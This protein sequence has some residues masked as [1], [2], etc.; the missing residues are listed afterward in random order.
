M[1]RRS[2]QFGEVRSRIC[3]IFLMVAMVAAV[4]ALAASLYRIT[5]TG[6]LPIMAVQLCFFVALIFF[7]LFRKRLPYRLCAGFVVAALLTLGLGG[8]WQVG[9]V[10]SAVVFLVV[11]PAVS[12]MFFGARVGIVILIA[13]AA[14]TGVIGAFTVITERLPP[15]D[16]SYYA[17]QP[18]SWMTM[19]VAWSLV[20][21]T[22]LAALIM[23]NEGLSAALRDANRTEDELTQRIEA[24][25]AELTREIEERR[26][27]ETDLRSAESALINA[28]A[29]LEQRIEARTKELRAEK[30][31]FR[32]FVENAPV[33][34]SLKDLDGAFTIINPVARAHVEAAGGSITEGQ[35]AYDSWPRD[36]ADTFR[37]QD[38]A[39][40]EAG[41]VQYYEVL[42]PAR[43]GERV[44][45]TTKFP[46]RNADGEITAIG[47]IGVDVTREREAE[48]KLRESEERFRSL[49]ENSPNAVSLKNAKGFFLLV[50]EQF[51]AL[52]GVRRKD[53]VGKTVQD[54]FQG[55]FAKVGLAHDRE[56]LE[57]RKAIEIVELFDRGDRTLRFLTTKFPIFGDDGEIAAI[58]AVHTNLTERMEAEEALSR[59]EAEY[60]LLVEMIPD[61]V[62]VQCDGKVVLANPSARTMFGAGS[63]EEMVGMDSLELVHPD[64]RDF[65]LSQR[66]QALIDQN[67]LPPTETRHQRLD[68]TPFDSEFTTGP[69]VWDGRCATVSLIRDVTERKRAAEQLLQAQKMET[70]GQLT[71]GVAHD[72]NNLLAIIMGNAE[73]LADHVEQI[74]HRAQVEAIIRA[75]QRGSDLTHRLLSFSRKQ[76]LA[77]RIVNVNDIVKDMAGI[78]R[79][80]LEETIDIETVTPDNLWSCE[81]DPAQLENALLNL[82][83]NARD[84][85]PNGGRLTIETANARVGDDSDTADNEVTPGEYVT[86]AVSDTGSGIPEEVQSH[87]FE[88]FFTTKEVGR[89][90]GLGL[91]MILGFVKQSGGGVKIDSKVGKGT[92]VR[93]YLPKHSGK[94]IAV[95]TGEQADAVVT[96]K[97]EVIL[98]A[99][100]DADLRTMI[101]GM[102]QSLGYEVLAS[103]N[104]KGA[105]DV[106]KES[107]GVNMLLTDVVLPGG[108]S[109]RELADRVWK[110]Y[111]GL[112]VLYMSGYTRDNVGNGEHSPGT[113]QLLEKP[114]RRADLARAVRSAMEGRGI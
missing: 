44:I 34:M 62:I 97:E 57:R 10:G 19:V 66:N 103:G 104:A 16:P 64:F 53:V 46:V 18:T 8:L 99:E 87:V 107:N 102:L 88:P 109:G 49:V 60:R 1:D 56:V 36:L 4:P 33:R 89:G 39:V 30:E 17:L 28:N 14:A 94:A 68:G 111:P 25:T 75:G 13:T 84:A 52:M 3:N 74:E 92:M 101:T 70:V 26:A 12:A 42:L 41:N 43:E 48:I 113:V 71:G 79:R 5:A 7:V 54:V 83:V 31:L 69:I 110:Q 45:N 98:L 90:T 32:S 24:R 65:V 11:A 91:S 61:A 9:L 37:E 77:P 2:R 23:Y 78:L 47:T 95:E 106:L 114:F 22:L 105:L 40:A 55:E 112:P 86:L 58:G 51:E 82:A 93:L 76:V 73:F 27:V 20:A 96:G 50:N 72:F 6:W 29:S 59:R 38:R 63:M 81:V 100:D 21:A 108:V 85:M 67:P 80:I 15:F 35:T